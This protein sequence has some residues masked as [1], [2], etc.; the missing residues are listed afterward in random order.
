MVGSGAQLDRKAYWIVVA[1]EFQAQFYTRD[2]KSG[3]LEELS[4]LQNDIAREKLED[5]VTDKAG[6]GFDSQGQGRHAYGK[7]KSDQKTQ[8]YAVFAKNIAERIKTGRQDQKFVRFAV[9]AAPRFLG[10]LR[11]ALGKAGV[12]PDMTID[13]EVTG[14]DTV[15]IQKMLDENE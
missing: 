1:D 14:R 9:I 6:R 3:P 7:E 2:S 12:E 5:V 10:V 15:F 8:S 4:L 11:N 13:K